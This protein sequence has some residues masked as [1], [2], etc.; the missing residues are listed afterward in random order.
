MNAYFQQNEDFSS[1]KRIFEA[2]Y[3]EAIKPAGR[4]QKSLDTLLSYLYIMIKALTSARAKAVLKAF[5]V[6]V[7]LVGFVGV[8]GAMEQGA[9]GLGAGLA[10]GAV[11]IGAEYLCLRGKRQVS[12]D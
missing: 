12:K 3:N 11:L 9:L 1:N 5:T 10:I 4:M 6:A 7:S 8:I 2:Y